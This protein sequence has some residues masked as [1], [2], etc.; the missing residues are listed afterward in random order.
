MKGDGLLCKR[1]NAIISSNFYITL[2]KLAHSI[3]IDRRKIEIALRERYGY[4]FRDL[5]N[6]ARLS[7]IMKLLEKNARIRDIAK[8]VGVTPNALS[9]FIRSKKGTSARE[10]RN[11]YEMI[12]KRPALHSRSVH[13]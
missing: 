10:L 2:H 6:K 1:I 9:R 7:H 5:K 11:N 3:G 4:G 12:R 13:I 8:G